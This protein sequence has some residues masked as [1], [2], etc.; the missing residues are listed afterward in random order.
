MMNCAGIN[1]PQIV[2][3]WVWGSEKEIILGEGVIR[4]YRESIPSTHMMK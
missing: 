4:F 2:A 3:G 1:S